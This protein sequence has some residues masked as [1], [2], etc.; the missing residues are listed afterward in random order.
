MKISE[1]RKLIREEVR[2]VISEVDAKIDINKLKKILNQASKVTNDSGKKLLNGDINKFLEFI[3]LAITSFENKD[4]NW[5]DKVNGTPLLYMILNNRYK[6][7]DKDK[8]EA[9]NE[10]MQEFSAASYTSETE[11]DRNPKKSINYLQDALTKL[12]QYIKS[13]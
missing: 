13:I 12:Q 2:N 1:F 5:G 3:Q 11:G 7:Q 10:I 9:F 6:G 4:A 8:W